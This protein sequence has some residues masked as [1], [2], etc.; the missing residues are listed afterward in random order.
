MQ[1][2]TRYVSVQIGI[3][4]YQTAEAASVSKN[5]FGDCK[6]L[7]NYT[8]ALLKAAGIKSFL[9]L[10]N[11][12]EYEEDINTNF[13]DIQFNHVILC[14]PLQ[15]DT[16]WLECTNQSVPFNYLGSFTCGR[17]VLLLTPEGGKLVRT[18][19]YSKE[20]NIIRTTGTFLFNT[21]G[22][23]SARIRTSYSGCYFGDFSSSFALQSEDEMK[24]ALYESMDYPDCAVTSTEYREQKSENPIAE[25]QYQINIK[26]FGTSNGKE[27]LFS[28]SVSKMEFL[29][30]DTI[31]LRVPVS[32]IT[33]DSLT[34]WMP[35]NYTIGSMPENISIKCNFGSYNYSIKTEGEK[36]IFYRKLELGKRLITEKDY[37]AFRDF[38]NNIARADRGIII[39]N[40]P[41]N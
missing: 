19:D 9:T 27:L 25:F 38:V 4:G 41:A 13:V 6:A 17:H 23:S 34:Y 35:P 30:K 5:G 15:S 36:I 10:V 24:K 8:M 11:A 20:Q 29:P 2:K 40:R 1:S 37:Y 28:P 22:T 16:V 31:L 7:S 39:L 18:P 21:A 33:I 26:G 32:D 3:G 14:V 12:G